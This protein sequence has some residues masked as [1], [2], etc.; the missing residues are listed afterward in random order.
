MPSACLWTAAG[1]QWQSLLVFPPP[2]AQPI[3]WEADHALYLYPAPDALVLADAAP[4]A[5]H[6][7]DSCSC[8]NP[9]R[10]ALAREHEGRVMLAGAPRDRERRSACH[11]C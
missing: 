8:L 7:F 1:A 6:I 5:Q 11:R 9:V 10:G 4:A 2:L 3:Y